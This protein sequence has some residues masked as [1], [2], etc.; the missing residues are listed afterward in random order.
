V[1]IPGGRVLAAWWRGLASLRPSKLW[2]GNLLFHSFEVPVR[3]EQTVPLEPFPF[4]VLQGIDKAPE[5]SP[6]G[7]ALFLALS[8]AL[9][10]RVLK[11]L[12]NLALIEAQ[13][14]GSFNLTRQGKEAL[15]LGSYSTLTDGRKDFCFVQISEKSEPV[16]AVAKF[17][18]YKESGEN[19][20]P[21]D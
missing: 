16:F 1:Q 19:P 10:V 2:F 20:E 7:I 9:L 4:L 18:E 12:E 14:T 6:L 13:S 8:P 15:R 21:T 3:L 17:S 5:K 11:S